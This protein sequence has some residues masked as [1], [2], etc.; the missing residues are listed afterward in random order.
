MLYSIYCTKLSKGEAFWGLGG[1]CL[2]KRLL[3]EWVSCCSSYFFPHNRS[4][5]SF[6]TKSSIV[7]SAICHLQRKSTLSRCIYA[8][9]RLFFFFFNKL[10][11]FLSG[12]ENVFFLLDGD[13]MRFL[14]VVWRLAALHTFIRWK[15]LNYSSLSDVQLR[16]TAFGLSA[17]T[18]KGTEYHMKKKT[19]ICYFN[20]N[21]SQ[22]INENMTAC[23]V[24]W[25]EPRLLFLCWHYLNEDWLGGQMWEVT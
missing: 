20:L 18:N 8:T 7:K 10:T 9:A 11:A 15:I 13:R 5:R 2:D 6:L 1:M 12:L 22:G 23:D 24:L 19:F 21:A 25:N 14:I 17:H 3:V 16:L 4:E